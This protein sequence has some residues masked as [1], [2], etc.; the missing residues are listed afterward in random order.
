MPEAS[1]QQDPLCFR[2]DIDKT[3]LSGIITEGLMDSHENPH[4]LD[5]LENFLEQVHLRPE[6]IAAVMDGE[7]VTYLE[8]NRRANRVSH[9]LQ[10]Q[11][12]GPEKIVGVCLNRS[13]SLAVTLLGVIK[14]GGCLLPLEPS[15]P[16]DR[17]IYMVE[18]C[19]PVMIVAQE[20][21][22]KMFHNQAGVFDLNALLPIL[23]G[24][25]F[26][27]PMPRLHEGNLRVIFYTSGSTGRPKGVMEIYHKDDPASASDRKGESVRGP[28]LQVTSTDRMLVKC[29]MSFAPF[30]WELL[31]P[32]SAGGT[33]IFAAT[34]GEQD[35]S[36]LLKLMANEAV[37]ISHFVPSSLRILLD[38]PEIRRCLSLA[39][40]CC[41]GE[42]LPD[43]LRELFFLKLNADI[44]LTYAATEA[45]GATW[46]HLHRNN[47]RELMKLDQQKT[48]KVYVLDPSGAQVPV[49]RKGE[50]YVEA[51]ERVR[52]YFH[53]P[54]LTAE[55]FLPDPFRAVPGTRLYRTGDLGK[56]HTDG[57]FQ[58]IGRTDQQVKIRGFR[59]EL[60]EIESIL[61]QHPG[62][63][64]V[65]ILCRDDSMGN[66]Q[67]IGYIQTKSGES[68]DADLLATYLSGHLPY[69]MVPTLY[70]FLA[71]FPL[72]ANGKVDRKSLPDFVPE[73]GTRAT[74]YVAPRNMLEETLVE[75]WQELL[76][77]DRIGIYDNFFSL[78][79]HS[80]LATQ[81][82]ARLRQILDFDLSH[83]LIFDH[84][85][86]AQL[87][88]EIH[89]LLDQVISNSESD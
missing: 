7:H 34:G 85:T 49:P 83:R 63:Q 4:C 76:N 44:F 5:P 80:L 20:P 77:R 37:T 79:G 27:N 73:D 56:I 74:G 81:V 1:H 58:V 16:R 41:S 24:E 8:L 82:M 32:L 21:Y 86:I 50:L 30:L 12:V 75:I 3:N 9:W 72:T 2:R 26:V 22:L 31:S 65:A 84:P 18:D 69:H 54:G 29:P 53:Q 40:V 61:R 57:N 67:L 39:S 10:R 36:Y 51:S 88:G 64:D 42:N 89:N 55:K 45:P 17:L 38:Q 11:G 47:F 15:Y 33:A 78:G 6:A 46:V 23:A 14:A 59:V 13:I 43:A 52:G 19:H 28:V 35:F 48:A 68:L 66:K 70:Q 62:V 25:S 71:Y 87:G 60:G